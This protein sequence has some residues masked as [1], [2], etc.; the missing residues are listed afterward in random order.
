MKSCWDADPKKRPSIKI[1]RSTFDRWAFR[2]VNGAEFDQAEAKRTKLIKSKKI[3]PEFAEK[4]HSEAIYTIQNYST[5]LNSNYISAELGFD[6]NTESLSSQ[7]L[8]STIQNFSTALESN[9]ISAELELDIDIESS[10]IQNFSTSLK[11]RRN[12]VLETHDNSAG[13]RIKTSSNYP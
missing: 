11:K 10:T 7:D 9:Y 12:G 2:R 6:I 1:I 5:T 13:K 3:G 4:R 8:N